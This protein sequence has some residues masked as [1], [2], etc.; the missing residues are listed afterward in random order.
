MKNKTLALTFDDGPSKDVMP[1]IL[2][3]LDRYQANA[4]FF[5]WGEKIT[6]EMEPLLHQAAQMGNELANH[7]MHHLHMSTLG[8][9][10]IRAEVEAVQVKLEAITGNAP[11]LFR[12]PY[13]DVS[14]LMRQVIPLPLIGGSDSRDWTPQTSTEERIRLVQEA[15]ADGAIILMHCFEGNTATVNALEVLLPWFVQE[16]FRVTTV[17]ELFAEKGVFPIAGQLYNA[18]PIC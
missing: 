18:V 9:E 17:R 6:A 7:S 1:R 15:A 5:I 10:E 11:V 8:V 3:L 12:P 2:E 13:L 4:T 14:A 16:G